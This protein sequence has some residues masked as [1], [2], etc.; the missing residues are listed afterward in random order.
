MDSIIEDKHDQVRLEAYDD[1]GK[2]V[3]ISNDGIDLETIEENNKIIVKGRSIIPKSLKE[4]TS[5]LEVYPKV[6]LTEL[7]H[8]I[9][10]SDVTPLQVRAARQDFVVGMKKINTKDKT[11]TYDFRIN[12]GNNMNQDFTF[13]HN[14]AR[15]EVTLVKESEED[16]YRRLITL[17]KS[18]PKITYDL[19]LPLILVKLMT[20]I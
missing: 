2:E 8:F 13:Y 19:E 10:F 17:L 14:F 12:N 4:E 3:N 6:A 11:V 15:N 1:K 7:D 20:S 9:Q 5:Y 16:I 18:L